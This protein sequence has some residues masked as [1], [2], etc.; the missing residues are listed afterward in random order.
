MK[1]KGPPS[2]RLLVEPH[3]PEMASL[4][5]RGNSAPGPLAHSSKGKLDKRK[6]EEG[7]RIMKGGSG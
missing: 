2:L 3:S 6:G 4:S 1:Q 5:T 7:D